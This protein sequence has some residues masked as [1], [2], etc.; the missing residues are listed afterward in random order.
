MTRRLQLLALAIIAVLSMGANTNI[1]ASATNGMCIDL[2]DAE[3][4]T[5]YMASLC[6]GSARCTFNCDGGDLADVRCE[7]R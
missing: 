2:E 1:A 4:V 7:C 5:A 6:G 3:G